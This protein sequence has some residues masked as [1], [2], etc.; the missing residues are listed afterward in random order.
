MV[1]VHRLFG[2]HWRVGA[3]CDISGATAFVMTVLLLLLAWCAASAL[4]GAV[5]AAFGY[6][7]S[8]AEL[9]EQRWQRR[10]ELD[11]PFVLAA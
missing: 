10:T 11:S 6:H 9:A 7:N 5:S 8:R 4:T 3:V 1:A 2:R